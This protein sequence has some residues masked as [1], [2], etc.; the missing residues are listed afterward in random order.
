VYC[1]F[2]DTSKASDIVLYSGAFKRLLASSSAMAERPHEFGDFKG[3][4]QFD[5]AS[6]T[7]RGRFPIGRN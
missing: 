3:V 1:G 7:S 4:C 6:W 2:L 5:I